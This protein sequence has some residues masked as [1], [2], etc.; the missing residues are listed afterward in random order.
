M[1]DAVLGPDLARY[2]RTGDSRDLPPLPPAELP[3]APG[4]DPVTTARL[5]LVRWYRYLH[6]PGVAGL[7]EYRAALHLAGTLDAVP[8][9]LPPLPETLHA[10]VGQGGRRGRWARR[11]ARRRATGEAEPVTLGAALIDQLLFLTERFEEA[12]D[13]S[14]LDTVLDLQTRLLRDGAASAR[15]R[16]ALFTDRARLMLAVGELGAHRSY[17]QEGERCA[18]E[19]AER[20]ARRVVPDDPHLADRLLLK[21]RCAAALYDPDADPSGLER[22]V[23][24]LR[25]AA[26]AAARLTPVHLHP[27][28]ELVATLVR[29]Y[30]AGGPQTALA[31]AV[32]AARDL[33]RATDA[34]DRRAPEHRRWLADIQRRARPLLGD[35]AVDALLDGGGGR[36]ARTDPARLFAWWRTAD[37]PSAAPADRRQAAQ[38]LLDAVPADDEDRPGA[39][40]LAAEMEVLYWESGGP[41]A[42]LERARARAVRAVDA[43]PPG[44]RLAGR[45]LAAL[46]R[47][48]VRLAATASP[49]PDEALA[50]EAVGFVRRAA[51]ELPPDEPDTP[52]RLDGLAALLIDAANV[53]VDETLLPESVDLQRRALELTPGDAPFR[54]FRMSTLAG[55]LNQLAEASDDVALGEEAVAVARAAADALPA[56]HPNKHE[57]L[58]NLATSVLRWKG[59]GEGAVARLDEAERLYRTGRAMLPDDHP[60]HAR[61]LSSISQVLHLRH[62]ETGDRRS[63]VEAVALAREA[64]RLTP[65]HDVFRT[66]RHILLARPCT[67]LYDLTE[68]EPEAAALRAE[69]LAAWEVAVADDGLPTRE[70]QE[71]Q[72]KRARLALADGD[73]HLALQALED[74]LAEIPRIARRSLSGP[75]RKGTARQAPGLAAQA[76]VAAIDSGRPERAVELLEQGRAILYAQAMTGWR[77]RALLR[78]VDPGAARRLEEIDA[79]LAEA[80]FFANITA[81]EVKSQVRR[82]SGRVVTKSETSYD[83]RSRAAAGTR[84][85]AAER[86]AIL[87]RFAGTP[88]FAEA[89]RP[90]ALADLRRR[91]AGSPVVLV[92]AHR[93]RGDALLVPADPGRDIV[94]IPLPGLTRGAVERQS[95]LM[96]AAVR[97]A[98]DVRVDHDRRAKAQS[99]LHAV[100]E[101]LWDEVAGPVLSR[102]PDTA[103]PGAPRPRLWWCPVGPVVRLPLHAAGHH[104][105]T[106]PHG[107]VDPPPTVID[108]VIS[109]YTPT[110]AA[111]AHSLRD[112][113]RPAPATA[114]STGA[115]VVA[116]RRTPHLPPLPQAEKEVAVVLAA[117]PG[118]RALI[119]E[120]AD[121]AAVE[122]ALREHA[123]VHFACHGDNDAA[124]AILRGGGLHLFSGETLTAAQIQETELDHGALAFLSACSTAEPHP[125]LPDEPMHLAAAFQ[126]AGFRSVIGTLWRAPDTPG[127]AGEVYAALTARGTRPPD[128][129]ASAEALNTAVRAVRDAYRASPTRWAAYLHTGA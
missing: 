128:T 31:D 86:E 61:F 81:V 32:A 106:G 97:D 18:A 89:V 20:T 74:V 26:E 33:D 87:E 108:R 53:L 4:A 8:P 39:L 104:I 19:A 55:V 96:E 69:A 93:D 109:S 105:R 1:D 64:V 25:R 117:I 7:P 36:A 79:G 54:P 85:L 27:Q 34:R 17:L 14:A 114:R 13:F 51:A 110:L 102:L 10:R 43:A 115:L 16:A 67:A 84:R 77:L 100:L 2:A 129:A 111:L 92:L 56:D 46:A 41:D 99:E 40:V 5:V 75:V 6:L 72:K 28:R 113:P 70:R 95:A 127:M 21:A 50:E 58:F 123:V 57:L 122:E 63:L 12:R 49:V 68:E 118:S 98:T 3:P 66:E 78:T 121:L 62:R 83:P 15:E 44:H 11:G 9:G 126:L 24:D 112:A 29:W 35:A 101:W 116:A 88:E 80:D 94:H 65:A 42:S 37:D 45:A 76:A 23:G 30:E 125:G 73:P 47:S 91:I 60:D 90:P 71:A 82:A 52:S 103:R 107:P 48:T 59:E 119:D 38:A 124:M 120:E 22:A